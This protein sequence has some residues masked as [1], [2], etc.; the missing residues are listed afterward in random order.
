MFYTVYK[1]TNK[2]NGKIYIGVHKTNNLDDD[3]LGS[4]KILKRAIEK[5]GIE[6]FEKEILAVFDKA[7]DMFEMESELV[8]EDFV[9]RDDTYNLKLGGFGGFDHLNDGSEEHKLRASKGGRTVDISHRING[10]LKSFEN[11]EWVQNYRKKLSLAAQ[12]FY[13]NGGKSGFKG[14]KHSEE[15]KH[16]ISKRMSESQK[17]SGNSQYGTMWIY[18]LELKE[19]KRINKDEKIPKGWKKGR[20]IKF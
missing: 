12:K 15:F 10:Y 7:S 4:G 2:I 16:R 1:T 14:K 9:E 19:S 20:K 5:Y 11:E 13:A 6:N 8:N 18:N 3:Y 17:G